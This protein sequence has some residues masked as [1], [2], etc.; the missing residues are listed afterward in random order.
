MNIAQ[1]IQSKENLNAMHFLTVYQTIAT[2]IADG[3]LSVDDL[4]SSDE[5]AS[6]NDG[7]VG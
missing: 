1:Y 2:L 7:R 4:K 3:I 5:Q 6:T